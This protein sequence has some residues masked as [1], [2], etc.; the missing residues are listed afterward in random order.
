MT[1]RSVGVR[2]ARV[3]GAGR[4]TMVHAAFRASFCTDD[5]TGRK[6][7]LDIPIHDFNVVVYRPDDIEDHGGLSVRGTGPME[8]RGVLH[9]SKLLSMWTSEPGSSSPVDRIEYT[10]DPATKVT[11][12]VG[13]NLLTV[14][15]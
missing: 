4:L 13:S 14:G 12:P 15:A 2:E 6:A 7:A 5:E 1:E 3:Q 10:E 8:S 11:T 9:P